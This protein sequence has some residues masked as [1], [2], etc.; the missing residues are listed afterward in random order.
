MWHVNEQGRVED[1]KVKHAAEN[2]RVYI[3]VKETADTGI[4]TG[5]DALSLHDALPI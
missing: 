3:F 2:V 5:E 1:S 4:D